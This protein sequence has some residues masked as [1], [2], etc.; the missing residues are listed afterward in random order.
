MEQQWVF[1]LFENENVDG[2]KYVKIKTMIR[3]L[4]MMELL[5][6]AAIAVMILKPVTG[7]EY[8]RYATDTIH[9]ERAKVLEIVSEEL[10]LSSLG[11]D[12]QLGTQRIR[13]RLSE[14]TEVELNN[15]LTETHNV[16]AA[17]GQN[18]IVCVD[19]PENTDPYYTVYNYDRMPALV[20][21]VLVFLL[22]LLAVGKRKGFDAFLAILFTLT[23]ILRVMLPVLYK[24]G[25]AVLIGLTTVLLS[26]AVTLV[27]IHGP[28]EQ[29]LLGIVTTLMGELAACLLFAVFSGWLHLTGFQTDSA[30][31]LLLIKQNTGLDIRMLL[32][33]GMMVSSL[34]AVMDVAVSILGALREVAQASQK[35]Q[36]K[37]LFR[38]GISLGRDLIGT[39]SN[40]LIFAFA[41][42]A[43]AT[44]LV[45]YSYD[46]QPYQLLNSDYL[47]V[48]LAQGLCSTAAVILTVPFAAL[49]G[50][51]FFSRETKSFR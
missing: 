6:M 7:S 3:S 41:G 9:Y 36:K 27:L 5:V 18:I 34:G 24:G 8:R 40:T 35:P 26:T 19:A 1:W 47:T 20:S 23:F 11:T 44:M 10:E 42:G 39:M 32:S 43:L 2:D 21:L 22:L 45:F 31:S 13:V 46:V 38:S 28:T 25:S 15:Y 16:L 12:Q 4:L 50:A 30:E 48:E 49:M 14:G 33:A 29:C 37:M 51:I 17:E